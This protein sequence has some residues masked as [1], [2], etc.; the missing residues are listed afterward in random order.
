MNE[1]AATPPK[2]AGTGKLRVAG[3]LLTCLWL[4]LSFVYSHRYK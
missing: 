2:P 1:P 3:L 4:V